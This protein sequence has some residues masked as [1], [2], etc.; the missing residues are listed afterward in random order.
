MSKMILLLLVTTTV[1]CGCTKRAVTNKAAGSLEGVWV[2]EGDTPGMHPAD[3]LTFARKNGKNVLSFYS[4]GSPG[5]NWPTFAETEY[6]F[7]NG[8][9]YY[10]NYSDSDNGF[11]EVESFKWITPQKSFSLK[12]YQVLRFMSAD[13]RVT[14]IK[15]D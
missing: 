13:Y 12:L 10:R 5:P 4:A 8:K 3:T 6:R 2:R 9:L 1:V 11:L 14:Y 7:E 15:V